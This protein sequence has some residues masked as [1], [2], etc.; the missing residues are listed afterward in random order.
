MQPPTQFQPF[1]LPAD[2]HFFQQLPPF[3]LH[4]LFVPVKH[5]QLGFVPFHAG[6]LRLLLSPAG[7]AKAH[8][9]AIHHQHRQ[10][11]RRAGGSFFHRRGFEPGLGLRFGLGPEALH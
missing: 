11:G 9:E 3:S 4:C 8:L 6:F 7:P 2:Q 5:A 1:P 10:R